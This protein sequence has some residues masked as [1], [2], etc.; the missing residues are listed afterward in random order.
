MLIKETNKKKTKRELLKQLSL[1]N[2]S[3]KLLLKIFK[4]EL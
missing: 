2:K 3:L 1:K 4:L